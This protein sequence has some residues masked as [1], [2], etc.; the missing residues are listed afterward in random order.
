MTYQV[1]GQGWSEV[2]SPWPSTSLQF[3]GAFSWMR[4][5]SSLRLK[6]SPALCQKATPQL[7]CCAAAREN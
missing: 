3:S 6:A 7:G 2:I 4:V 5:P 1:L